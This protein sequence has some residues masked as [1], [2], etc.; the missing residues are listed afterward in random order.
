MTIKPVQFSNLKSMWQIIF[1]SI[2]LFMGFM[3]ARSLV[4]MLQDE[5]EE[6]KLEINVLKKVRQLVRALQLSTLLWRVFLW[7]IPVSWNSSCTELFQLSTWARVMPSR[8]CNLCRAISCLVTKYYYLTK[9]LF[10][11]LGFVRGAVDPHLCHIFQNFYFFCNVQ[12][13][14]DFS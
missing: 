13:K 11:F 1:V 14:N 8:L 3:A 10:Q 6:I 2:V 12:S 7:A 4:D 9:S 5:E